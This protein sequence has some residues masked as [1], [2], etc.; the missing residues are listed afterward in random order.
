M[1]MALNIFTLLLICVQVCDLKKTIFVKRFIAFYSINTSEWKPGTLLF[2]IPFF[3][4]IVFVFL[5]FCF[6]VFLFFCFFVFCIFLFFCILYFY[7]LYFYILYFV[8]FH[9]LFQAF[10]HC[11]VNNLSIRKVRQIEQAH[12]QQS[13]QIRHLQQQLQLQL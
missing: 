11:K 10:I 6:F 12:D 9:T 13:Q 1:V 4:N 5:F 3:T 2:F 7:I 8:C